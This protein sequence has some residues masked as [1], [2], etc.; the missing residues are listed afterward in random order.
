MINV[1]ATRMDRPSSVFD[2]SRSR[3]RRGPPMEEMVLKFQL[4]RGERRIRQW[5][6]EAKQNA[7]FGRVKSASPA[8]A[9][10]DPYE[11]AVGMLN[12]YIAIE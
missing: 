10:D 1:V 6:E 11:A 5:F 8:Q 7:S 2:P 3:L 9:P 12:K 4:R